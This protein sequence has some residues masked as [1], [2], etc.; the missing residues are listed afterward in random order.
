M[1][2]FDLV[3]FVEPDQIEFIVKVL[4][5]GETN[6]PPRPCRPFTTVRPGSQIRQ[7]CGLPDRC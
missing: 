7:T 6:L 2:T 1:D 5:G 3:G 4:E